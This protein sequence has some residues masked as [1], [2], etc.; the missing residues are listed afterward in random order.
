MSVIEFPADKVKPPAASQD[1]AFE[2][3][4]DRLIECVGEIAALRAEID[5]LHWRLDKFNTPHR[6]LAQD[7]LATP[8]QSP[9]ERV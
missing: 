2:W 9:L 7:R 1:A 5:E 6:S 8:H 3:L 4:A